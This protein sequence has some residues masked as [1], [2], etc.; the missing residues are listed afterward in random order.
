MI[1]GGRQH[2]RS[3]A[4]HLTAWLILVLTMAGG[5]LAERASA[6]TPTYTSNYVWDT[7]RR[8]LTMI[9]EPDTGTGN[10]VAT[11][12]VYD[13]DE[14][15]IE[16]DRGMTTQAN[17]SDF[18]ALEKTT[19]AYD[20]VGNR[21]QTEVY[22]GTATPALALAQ[23]AYDADNRQTCSVARMN[24]AAYSSLLATAVSGSTV[25]S[26]LSTGACTLG[27]EGANGNDRISQLNYDAAGQKTSEIRAVGTAKQITYGIYSYTSDG[28]LATVEDAN[29]NVTTYLYDGFNRLHETDFPINTLGANQSSTT[30]YNSNC[31]SAA[32]TGSNLERYC[33]DLNGNRTALHKRD[34]S[35]ITYVY[36]NLNREVAKHWPTGGGSLD[37][38]SGYN[39]S[40]GQVGYDL[41]G[42][43]IY[44]HYASEGGSGVNYSYDIT[45]RLLTETTG[46]LTMTYAYDVAGNRVQV[47]WPDSFYAGY[48]YDADNNLTTVNENGATSGVQ[49]LA[50]YSYNYSSTGLGRR[51]GVSRGDGS[52][53]AYSYDNAD[54]LTNLADTIPSGATGSSEALAFTYN[55]ASQILSRAGSSAAY[56]Y[57]G[58]TSGTTNTAY[59]GLN[60]DGTIAALGTLPGG[61]ACSTSSPSYGY[62]SN[63]SLLYDGSRAFCYDSENRLISASIPSASTT[64][65]LAYDPLGRLQTYQ[66]VISGTTAT[67]TF[68]YDGDRLSAEYNGSTLLR[69][70]VHG[71]GSDVPLVWYEGALGTTDRRFLH[72]DNQGSV[73]AWSNAASATPISYGAYGE[74]T[75][76]TGSR[77]SYTG[78]IILGELKLYHYKARVYDP[79]SGRFLQTDPVGYGPDINWY[80]YVREDPVNNADPSGNSGCGTNGNTGTPTAAYCGD[81]AGQ[82]PPS[83]GTSMVGVSGSGT[84]GIPKT[85]IKASGSVTVGVAF[86]KTEVRGFVSVGGTVGP[87]KGAAGA[88]TGGESVS[89]GVMVGHHNGDPVDTGGPFKHVEGTAA[90][91]VAVT[92]NHFSGT[93][94]DGSR[95]VQGTSVTVGVGEGVSVG[96]GGSQT[97][98]S[99]A[100]NVQDLGDYVKDW[101]FTEPTGGGP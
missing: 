100:V 14:E 65:S 23:T 15:L 97:W 55:P 16:T 4:A 72:K 29:L 30:D 26:T 24:A 69:R 66:T 86:N 70:Y 101:A 56:D 54:R 94:A 60:R 8:L 11:K 46:S 28:K 27:I 20:Q 63:G 53:A 84:A 64:A 33:Y 93:S 90:D 2:R 57:A 32:P 12:F 51:I 42:H 37:V 9:I 78:Q 92:P 59:D 88:T 25:A 50:V 13:V 98:V 19:Y 87:G 47:T 82:P 38:Y 99:P 96:G 10:R 75:S 61:T 77:F 35:I 41:L 21:I 39:S 73:I 48:L 7:N 34:G 45:G 80:A 76:W 22:N 43:Q 3:L 40:T 44:A 85:P 31:T 62:D 18:T 52:G 89:G 71:L 91:G 83:S 49:L 36:D 5:L 6:T 74:P 68:L 58:Y 79:S 81:P 67:T 95:Q 1:T 17:G